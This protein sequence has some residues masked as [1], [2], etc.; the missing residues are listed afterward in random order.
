MDSKNNP[1]LAREHF[2]FTMS[3]GKYFHS[4]YNFHD[5]LYFQE[6]EASIDQIFFW[7]EKCRQFFGSVV[8]DEEEVSQ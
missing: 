8:D 7:Y 2:T 3:S 5:F 6:T 4:S 1:V